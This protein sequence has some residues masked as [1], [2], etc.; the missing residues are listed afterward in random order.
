MYYMRNTNCLYIYD[1]K[2]RKTVK[3][4]PL[5]DNLFIKNYKILSVSTGENVIQGPILL[6]LLLENGEIR[7][8]NFANG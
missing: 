6:S 8:L 5:L 7:I 3:N 2:S 4:F 1:L